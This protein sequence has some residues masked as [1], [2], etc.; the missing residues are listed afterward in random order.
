M[1]AKTKGDVKTVI[2]AAG[3]SPNMADGEKLLKV[4]ALGTV[5]VNQEFARVMDKGAG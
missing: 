1:Y 5:Y 4:N 2:N 3:M